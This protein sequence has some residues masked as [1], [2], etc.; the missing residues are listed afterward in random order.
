MAI[1]AEAAT[2][3]I[4]ANLGVPVSTSQAIVG[5]VLGVGLLKGVRTIDK[6]TLWRILFGWTGA[7]VIAAGVAFVFYQVFHQL[8]LS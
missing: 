6:S 2:V 7:P 5:A 8:G 3:H 4:Y 1:L